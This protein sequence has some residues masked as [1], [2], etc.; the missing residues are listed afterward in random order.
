MNTQ[1]LVGA[2]KNFLAC[3]PKWNSLLRQ[4]WKSV[5]VTN[6]STYLFFG[7]GIVI[8]LFF[9][10]CVCGLVYAC[11]HFCLNPSNGWN[12]CHRP[13]IWVSCPELVIIERWW[14]IH[15]ETRVH[16]LLPERNFLVP[17]RPFSTPQFFLL[18]FALET[19]TR[20]CILKRG[21]RGP[22]WWDKVKLL[23]L[24]LMTMMM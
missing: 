18:S 3:P 6:L 19:N 10:L 24:L 1:V 21:P 9:F 14:G 22:V 8:Y 20:A 23:L 13:S 7:N 2:V 17:F 5:I 12:L 11:G 15:F 16:K 4:H